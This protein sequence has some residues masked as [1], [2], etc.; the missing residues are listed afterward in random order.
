LLLQNG[1][2]QHDEALDNIALFANEVKPLLTKHVGSMAE[3]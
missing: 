3:V 1:P 2:L